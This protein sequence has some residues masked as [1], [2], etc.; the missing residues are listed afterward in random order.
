MLI[1]GVNSRHT[2]SETFHATLCRATLSRRM[3]AETVCDLPRACLPRWPENFVRDATSES[4]A[5]PGA[6][7]MRCGGRWERDDGDGVQRG[8]VRRSART[9]RSICMLGDVDHVGRGARGCR[10]IRTT[11]PN[12]GGGRGGGR[13]ETR[14]ILKTFAVLLIFFSKFSRESA[15]HFCR[16]PF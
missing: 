5:K 7:E 8:G 15:R 10:R 3:R 16:L 12:G 9:T 13:A 6:K 4:I 2:L 11:V 1:V 14:R